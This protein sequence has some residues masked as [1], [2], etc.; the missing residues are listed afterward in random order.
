MQN[1]RTVIYYLCILI[2]LAFA[3]FTND[4]NLINVQKTAIVTAIALDKEEGGFSLTAIVANPASQGDGQSNQGGQKQGAD[5]FATVGGKGST[6]AEALEDVNAK[7][8]W[9]PKLIFCR[10]LILGESLCNENVFDGLD[11]FLRNEY[12]ADD[13]LLA[14]A[15]GKA[16]E[17]LNATPPLKAAVSEAIE[18]VLSD[19][20]KL[21]GAVLTNTLR[22]F[23]VS[24]FSAGNSGYLP[25]L[26]K[27]KEEGGDVFSASETALFVNGKRIGTLDKEE[28]FALACVK[29]PLRLASYTVES[30]GESTTLLFKNNRRK[31]RFLLNGNRPSIEIELTVYADLS[32]RSNSQNLDGLSRREL[33]SVVYVAAADTL[34]KQIE[35]TFEHCRA[36]EFDAFDAI[37]KLQKYENEHYER[38][39]DSLIE[40]LQLTV[41]VRFAPIR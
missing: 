21:V 37:G 8:G 23:A 17:L 40:N 22:P 41:S 16:S 14:A 30:E 4:F 24:Y 32:D 3:F 19:Q 39:K 36:M 27:T 18:K 13:C 31:Q 28:T 11:F 38:L 10:L 2:A 6:V 1:K 20:S 7:T 15:D 12:A 35:R 5:G 29:N 33:R 25:L 26:K 9:Y 34:Q